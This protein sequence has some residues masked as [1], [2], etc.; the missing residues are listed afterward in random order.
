MDIAK[1]HGS[2]EQHGYMNVVMQEVTVQ[3][4]ERPGKIKVYKMRIGSL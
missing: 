1:R 4:D 2:K 3:S